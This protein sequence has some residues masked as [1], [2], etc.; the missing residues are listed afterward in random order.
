[1]QT[2]AVSDN[3][4]LNL[5]GLKLEGLGGWGTVYL[6]RQVIKG[7]CGNLSSITMWRQE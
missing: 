3:Q 2:A 4:I 7:A 6:N 1:M 5:E